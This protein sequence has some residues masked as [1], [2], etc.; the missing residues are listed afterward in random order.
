MALTLD[1]GP[2]IAVRTYGATE[3]FKVDYAPTRQ[4][5]VKQLKQLN[6]FTRKALNNEAVV[7]MKHSMDSLHIILVGGAG[8]ALTYDLLS[9][10]PD[11]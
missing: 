4:P 7:D 9:G 8:Y 5:S 11:M 10:N 1:L 3:V 2:N 6:I